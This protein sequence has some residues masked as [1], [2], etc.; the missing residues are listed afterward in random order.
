VDDKKEA[1]GYS[2]DLCK[3]VVNAIGEQIGV[4]DL[5]IKWVPVTTANRFETVAKGEAD[6]E[7]GSSSVT[8]GRM[9]QVD[10]SS[11]IFVDST[12]LLTWFGALGKPSRVL[13]MTYRLG[14]LPG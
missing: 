7:C 6:L 11:L 9:K 4:P 13:V 12:A 2:V 8:L 1:V 14:A 3:R 5:K 10:F